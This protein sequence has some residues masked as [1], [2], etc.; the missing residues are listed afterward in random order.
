MVE[1]IHNDFEISV[2]PQF[3][4]LKEIKAQL[5]QS[6]AGNAFMSGSGSTMVGVFDDLSKANDSATIF[7]NAFV[8]ETI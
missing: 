3:S 7:S 5:L 6:G 4:K 1:N 2:F 8:C